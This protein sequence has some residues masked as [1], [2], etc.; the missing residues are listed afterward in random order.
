MNSILAIVA[1][2]IFTIMRVY[3]IAIAAAILIVLYCVVAGVSVSIFE[4]IGSRL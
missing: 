2:L 1:L 3:Y 4:A